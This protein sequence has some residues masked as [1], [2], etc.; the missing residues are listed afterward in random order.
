[1]PFRS[2]SVFCGLLLSVIACQG[3]AQ[4]DYGEIAQEMAKHGEQ[5]V[6]EA[7]GGGSADPDRARVIEQA[8]QALTSG[9]AA[10]PLQSPVSPPGQAPSSPPS[11]ATPD[12]AGHVVY[13]MTT[14]SE[15]ADGIIQL[16]ASVAGFNRANPDIRIARAHVVIRGLHPGDV[17]ITDTIGRLT[18]IVGEWR[19]MAM[20]DARDL[21]DVALNPNPFREFA[22]GDEGPVLTVVSPDGS[23]RSARGTYS[24]TETMKALPGR[25]P[26]LGPTVAY[27]ERDLL[28]EIEERIAK[29]DVEGIKL[30]AQKRLWDRLGTADK[31]LPLANEYRRFEVS[32]AFELQEPLLDADGKVLIP[33]GQ[34]FNPMDRLP[35]TRTVVA[36]NPSRQVELDRVG[37]LL[38]AMPASARLGVRPLVTHLAFPGQTDARLAQQALE[39]HLGMRVFLLDETAI[40]RFQ[41]SHTPTM[42]TGDNVRRLLIVEEMAPMG[43]AAP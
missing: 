36:F 1:M 29:L 3:S 18:P 32:L 41:I 37:Q 34:R 9:L 14:L 27:A 22:V 17:A 6:Q 31:E 16:E 38:A 26:T 25:N 33:A 23:V 28:D 8:R 21:I 4:Q 43:K 12:P 42:V 35:F 30:G 10:R 13:L 5:I 40:H 15:L 24:L 19:Q 2:S 39:S 11:V 7:L 20:T